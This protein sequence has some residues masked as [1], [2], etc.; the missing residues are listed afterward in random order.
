MEQ[1]CPGAAVVGPA[2][3]DD[4]RLT[5]VWD[6]PGWGGGVATVEPAKD[7]HIWG[8]LWDLT[9]EHV[10]SLDRYEGIAAGVYE[11]EHAYVLC[12]ESR[13]NA[14]IYVATDSRYKAPSARYVSALIRG[15][16]AFAV[17][18][19]YIERLRVLRA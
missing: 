5:F 9:D 12:L 19:D 13:V 4:H 3:L 7:D 10:Q 18:D 8:V 2:R 1:R 15:A 6:S 16:K 17:P 11:R 14:M